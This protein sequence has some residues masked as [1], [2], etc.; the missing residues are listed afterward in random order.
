MRLMLDLEQHS[1]NWS[2][3]AA[4]ELNWIWSCAGVGFALELELRWS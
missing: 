2:T 1:V 3:G 4:L